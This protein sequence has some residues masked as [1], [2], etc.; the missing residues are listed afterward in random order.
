MTPPAAMT[1]L[2][3]LDDQALVARKSMVGEIFTH[4]SMD[5][6][7]PAASL[8]W[9]WIIDGDY[10]FILP[11]GHNEPDAKPELYKIVTDPDEK[12]DLASSERAVVEALTKKLNAWWDPAKP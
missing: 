2:N 6:E 3:L 10:K 9:R 8:R 7:K 1:G 5:L 11:D 12:A 4:N